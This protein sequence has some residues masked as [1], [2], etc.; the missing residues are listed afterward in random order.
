LAPS[1]APVAT[2]M[3]TGTEPNPVGLGRALPAAG[4]PVENGVVRPRTM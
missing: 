3:T 4:E 1:T 2:A